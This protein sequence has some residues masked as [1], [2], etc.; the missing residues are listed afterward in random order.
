VT[1]AVPLIS[2]SNG[3]ALWYLTRST[4]VVALLLLT[5]TV[6]LG[7]VASVGWTTERWPRFLSQTVHRNLSL[8]CLAFVGLHIVTTVSDGYVPIGFVDAFLPLHSPYRPVW[9][10]LGA[11]TFDLLLAVLVTSALRHRIRYPTWRFVHWLAYLCWPIAMFHA[12]GSGSD[13]SLPVVLA[14]DAVCALSVLLS[15]VWRVATGR[16]FRLSKRM[17]ASIGTVVT[18]I[19]LGI[20]AALGPLRPGWSRRSGTSAA[21]LAQIARKNALGASSISSA[22]VPANSGPAGTPPVPFSYAV[23]GTQAETSPDSQ[24]NMQ[25]AITL[26]LNDASSTTLVITLTGSALRTGGLILSSGTVDFGGLHGSVIGL[27]GGTITAQLSA[28]TR[29]RLTAAL[30]LDGTPGQISGTVTGATESG[31]GS[32]R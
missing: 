31:A 24:G 8:L 4:G 28:P 12:L 6:V 15:V 16:Q 11:L 18:V 3:R 5:A 30:F 2:G 26:H 17:A 14:I 19:A 10:G 1:S 29:E 7:V 13:S 21:L 27:N 22:V 32:G 23:T 20:F 25:V 9:I